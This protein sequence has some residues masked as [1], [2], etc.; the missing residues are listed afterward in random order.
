MFN[1]RDSSFE[2]RSEWM[3][4]GEGRTLNTE[5][6][7]NANV[8]LRTSNAAW[9]SSPSLAAALPK[10]RRPV[11]QIDTAERRGPYYGHGRP[12]QSQRLPHAR[13]RAVRSR[14]PGQRALPNRKRSGPR[15]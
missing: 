12:H 1:V 15:G 8:E 6:R 3:A 11:T 2:V 5:S 14:P 10:C 4:N 13:T 9:P 7:R